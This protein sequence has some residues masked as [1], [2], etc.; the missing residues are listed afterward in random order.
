M[1]DRL[2]N[3]KHAE[4]VFN[5]TEVKKRFC[6]QEDKFEIE[7]KDYKHDKVYL[8]VEKYILLENGKELIQEICGQKILFDYSLI[9]YYYSDELH[10]YYFVNTEK[11]LRCRLLENYYYFK[12]GKKVHAFLVNDVNHENVCGTYSKIGLE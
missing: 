4:F 5:V 10:D 7:I 3:K 6:A 12:Y 9:E 8:V 11:Y 2:T 1:I